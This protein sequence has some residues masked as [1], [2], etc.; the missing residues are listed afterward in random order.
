MK[1]SSVFERL[2]KDKKG[3]FILNI[4]S[5]FFIFMFLELAT[6]VVATVTFYSQI[7]SDITEFAENIDNDAVFVEYGHGTN[8]YKIN[9]S[10]LSSSRLLV[11]V[12]EDDGAK[13]NLCN[14]QLIYYLNPEF[15][16]YKSR[17]DFETDEEYNSHLN[18]VK[19]QIKAVSDNEIFSIDLDDLNR[20][21][22]SKVHNLNHDDYYLR[23]VVVKINNDKLP[24]AS[25]LKV[26]IMTNSEEQAIGSIIN[27]SVVTMFFVFIIAI[28]ASY[29]L[30]G[31]AIK[32]IKESLDKQLAFVSDAS[33]ELRTPLAIVQSKLEN[34]LTKSEST[35]YDVSDDIA[36][37]LKEISRLNKLSNELL[38]LARDDTD[39]LALEK[40]DVRLDKL[41]NDVCEPFVE[42]FSIH[43]KT[44][45]L[46][47]DEVTYS[48][49]SNL[50]KQ[51]MI[52][53]LDNANRYTNTS[54]QA[55]VKLYETKNDVIIE[56]K[57]TG[58]GIGEEA[59]E[60]IFE[61]FY[62][63][64]KARSRETGGNGLGLSIAKSIVT[65]HKGII[66]AIHN[67]PKGVVFKINLPK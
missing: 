4:V 62:R 33:H 7:D 61:R 13:A 55:I 14:D 34:I 39:R 47:L 57:D 38:M 3:L 17:S 10:Y 28:F 41:L 8:V 59:I 52:I 43:E 42:I 32:S 9:P 25:Y 50:I 56:V 27:I 1:K 6:G 66:E 20:L 31:K 2:K 58:I 51:L 63:E 44:M 53:L 45:T 36:D 21:R 24:E 29:F 67:H 26:M 16:G 12:Y 5:F 64:D 49:D 30:S 11:I 60:H 40:E 37:S 54:D 15:Q 19:E 48:C 46:L 22:T 18:E 65:K 35:V 23:N